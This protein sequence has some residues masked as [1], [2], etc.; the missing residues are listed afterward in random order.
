VSTG[1]SP[2]DMQTL[3]DRL[4]QQGTANALPTFA[5]A[6]HEDVDLWLRRFTHNATIH[7]WNDQKKLNVFVSKLSG[8]AEQFLFSLPDSVKTSY[9]TEFSLQEQL[10][11]RN[12]RPGESVVQY[13]NEIQLLVSRLN[14]QSRSP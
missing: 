13:A 7:K 8:N 14:P 10:R 6:P 9:V 11:T 4:D 12:H 1:F 3:L 2:V 5:G